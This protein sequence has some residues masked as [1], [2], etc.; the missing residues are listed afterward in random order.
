V[1]VAGTEAAFSFE[2]GT[3]LIHF[4]NSPGGVAVEVRY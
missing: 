3:L 4:V 1:Q 2:N